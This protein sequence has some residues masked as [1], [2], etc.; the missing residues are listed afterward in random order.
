[1]YKYMYI[2]NINKSCKTTNFLHLKGK[3]NRVERTLVLE[4]DPYGFKS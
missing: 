1:M 2:Q 4:A 3:H